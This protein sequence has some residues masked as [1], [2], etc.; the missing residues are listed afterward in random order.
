MFVDLCLGSG[1]DRS[2]MMAR[3]TPAADPSD[4]LRR[5]ALPTRRVTPEIPSL[6]DLSNSLW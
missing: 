5:R 3:L 4:F 6:L 1:T 2:T